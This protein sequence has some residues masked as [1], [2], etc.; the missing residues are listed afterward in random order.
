MQEKISTNLKTPVRYI[1]GVGPKKAE[2]F[3]KAGV[4][5]LRDLLYYAPRRYLDR[6]SATKISELFGGSDREVVVTSRSAR[7]F[8]CWRP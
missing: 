2:P 4:L 7:S 5:T 8:I 6:S 1:K 3:E